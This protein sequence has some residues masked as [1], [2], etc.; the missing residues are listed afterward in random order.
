[1]YIGDD[2][3][4]VDDERAA[5]RHPQR[6]VQHRTALGDVDPLAREHRV[7]ACSDPCF[8]RELDEQAHR[9]VRDPVLRV[10]EREAGSFGRQPLAAGRIGGEEIPEMRAGD[11]V[12]VLLQAHADYAVSSQPA[13][14]NGGRVTRRRRVEPGVTPELN[15]CRRRYS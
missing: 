7:A 6:D 14:V 9:F 2:V 1:M 4:A 11:L 10:V 13:S 8:I 15:A 3:A 5:A 12:V